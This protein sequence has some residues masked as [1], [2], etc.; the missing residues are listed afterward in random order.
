MAKPCES[1]YCVDWFKVICELDNYEHDIQ[2]I[3]EKI[4]IAYTTIHGWKMGTEPRHADGERLVMLWCEVTGKPRKDLP[5][6][7]SNCWWCYHL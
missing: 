3:S 2:K 6:L 1:R 7:N 5:V 4:Y